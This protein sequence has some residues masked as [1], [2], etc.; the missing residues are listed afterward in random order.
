[1]CRKED[2]TTRPGGY[3]GKWWEWQAN[4][5][6]GGLLLPRRLVAACVESLTDAPTSLGPPA[7]PNAKRERAA[8][9]VAAAFEVN[10]TVAQIR[11]GSV[12]PLGEQLSL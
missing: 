8:R 3:D 11:I 10:L 1:M 2:L 9:Q 4:Q 5:A 12:F 6:I 7:L